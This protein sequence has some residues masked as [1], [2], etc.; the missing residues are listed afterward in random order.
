MS[1]RKAVVDP[2]LSP[3][4][5]KATL[6][7]HQLVDKFFTKEWNGYLYRQ[8]EAI[9][10]NPEL[11]VKPMVEP[12]YPNRFPV[13]TWNW[14]H[15]GHPEY[16]LQLFELEVSQSV[17]TDFY[18]PRT[19]GESMKSFA[20]HVLSYYRRVHQ[21]IHEL[22]LQ[23]YVTLD[24]KYASSATKSA[25]DSYDEGAYRVLQ[26]LIAPEQLDIQ[27]RL[28]LT[29]MKEGDRVILDDYR[30]VHAYYVFRESES[31]ELWLTPYLEDYGYRL[32][33]EAA[34]LFFRYNQHAFLVD[35]HTFGFRRIHLNDLDTG[36][37]P[38]LTSS[39]DESE[40]D[41]TKAQ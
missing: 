12:N 11:V 25:R 16:T 40:E 15:V 29:K 6:E 14:S 9:R 22:W 7:I 8:A 17:K 31:Q 2:T 34:P 33:E 24:A 32:P 37:P 28:A 41:Q 38:T 19:T 21:R 30:N 23:H 4:E 3:W 26:K 39:D 10:K 18:L 35:H 20:D 36:L 1:K 27:L 5:K 13:T